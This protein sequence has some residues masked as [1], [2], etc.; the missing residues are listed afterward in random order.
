[1]DLIDALCDRLASLHP[2][3]IEREI[4]VPALN[5]LLEDY[6]DSGDF[7]NIRKIN[8]ILEILGGEATADIP[9]VKMEDFTDDQKEWDDFL[10]YLDNSSYFADM[11]G[12]KISDMWDAYVEL[13]NETDCCSKFH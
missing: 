10:G 3:T 8:N 1:M 7:L 13:K 12:D 5:Q 9:I 2:A 11:I 6:K 4:I